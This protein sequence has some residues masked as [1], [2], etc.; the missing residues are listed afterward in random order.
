MSSKKSEG[1]FG[2]L[3]AVIGGFSG[4]IMGFDYGD[5]LG[6]FMG[7]LG[8]GLVGLW[9]GRAAD[10]LMKLAFVIIILLINASIRRFLWNLF[11]TALQ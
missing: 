11:V 1:F 3:L 9:I 7:G 5:G 8:L 4:A 6:M 10:A 2:P